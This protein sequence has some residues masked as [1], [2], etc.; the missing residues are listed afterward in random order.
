MDTSPRIGNPKPQREQ[1]R[2]LARAHPDALLSGGYL[3]RRCPA[4]RACRFVRYGQEQLVEKLVGKLGVGDYFG[5]IAL[6]CRKPRQ[7]TVTPARPALASRV[8]IFAH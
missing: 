1:R 7:A 5:E 3:W 2:S 6:L 8:R 4:A